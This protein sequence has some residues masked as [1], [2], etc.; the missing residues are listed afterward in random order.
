[1]TRRKPESGFAMLMVFVLAAAIAITLY[2]E[3]PRVVFESERAKEQILVDRGTQYKRAIQLYVRYNMIHSR[4]AK[5]PTKIDDLESTNNMRFLRHRYKDPLTGK[6]EWRLIHIGPTGQLTDSLIQKFD[7]LKDKEK[8]KGL[9]AGNTTGDPN[10]AV[11]PQTGQPIWARGR[12]SDKVLSGAGGPPPAPEDPNAPFQPAQPPQPVYAGQPGYPQQPGQP[13]IPQYPQIPVGQQPG[14]APQP[15]P[16]QPYNPLQPNQPGTPGQPFN[17]GQPGQPNT[18]AGLISQILTTPRQPPAGIGYPAPGGF[19]QQPGQPG[20]PQQSGQPGQPAGPN[21]GFAFNNNAGGNAG[22]SSSTPSNNLSGGAG[23][24]AGVASTATG[25]GIKVIND[26]QKFKEWE[27]V[28]D[29]TKDKTMGG[30]VQN[31]QM[32]NPL[33]QN[34]Q[35]QPNRRLPGSGQ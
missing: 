6:D 10:S 14:F 8:D 25:S 29:F 21:S 23:G 9:T 19:P 5:Y 2:M 30:G 33:Q 26:R 34:P 20:F 7:P 13:G 11:D 16:N 3:M 18:A 28:Y 1:M 4:V 31:P 24:I 17:P 15:Y 35:P 12:P 27:F 22:I 32:Q